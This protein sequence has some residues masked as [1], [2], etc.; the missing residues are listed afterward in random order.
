MHRAEVRN[1]ASK[2]SCFVPSCRRLAAA[3]GGAGQFSP[4]RSGLL[5]QLQKSELAHMQS[6]NE[7]TPSQ[8]VVSAL[9]VQQSRNVTSAMQK[10]KTIYATFQNHVLISEVEKKRQIQNLNVMLTF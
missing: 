9:L 2:E 8:F 1:K 10:I 6:I 5:W 3:L 4:L 7:L